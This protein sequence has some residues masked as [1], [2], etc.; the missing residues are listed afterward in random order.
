MGNCSLRSFAPLEEDPDEAWKRQTRGQTE[1]KLYTLVDLK[2][3]D[4]S[5]ELVKIYK[6]G[7]REALLD[8]LKNANLLARYLYDRGEGKIVTAEDFSLY[9]KERQKRKVSCCWTR[10]RL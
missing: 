8:K 10:G 5:A 6:Q 4:S 3:A 7:Q 1:N 2:G 9:E